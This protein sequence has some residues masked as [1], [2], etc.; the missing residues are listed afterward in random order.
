VVHVRGGGGAG[1]D[2]VLAQ[3]SQ[4]YLKARWAVELTDR[5][6]PGAR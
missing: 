6:A 1:G 3:R 5:P 2:V 4:T